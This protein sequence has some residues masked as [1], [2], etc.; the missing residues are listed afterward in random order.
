M[1]LR[2]ST[3]TILHMVIIE[4]LTVRRPSVAAHTEGISEQY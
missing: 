2:S 3:V 1:A 4:A